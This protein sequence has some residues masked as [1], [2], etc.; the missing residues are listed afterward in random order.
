MGNLL[1]EVDEDDVLRAAEQINCEGEAQICANFVKQRKNNVNALNPTRGDVM[2]AH[3]L[4]A[5]CHQSSL[6]DHW[7]LTLCVD[8]YQYCAGSSAVYVYNDLGAPH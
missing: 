5:T 3:G 6:V 1:N 7:H 4:A 2:V 8:Y